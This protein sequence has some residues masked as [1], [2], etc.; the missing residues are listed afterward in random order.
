MV[1]FIGEYRAK[2]DD[3]GRLVFPS[4]FKALLPEGKPQ[5]FVIKKTASKCT[6][7]KSGK[8]SQKKSNP[9]LIS[10]TGRTPPS[11]GST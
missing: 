3:K 8:D 4:A 6:H 9:D 7:T 10:S 5:L 11:G 1:K 2:M